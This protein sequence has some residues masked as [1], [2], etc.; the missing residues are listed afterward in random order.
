MS[1]W[2][3]VP[4]FN[5]ELRFDLPYWRMIVEGS[6]F[7]FLFVNDGSTDRTQELIESISL[8]NLR[9]LQLLSNM[10]KAEAIRA[11]C[12]TLINQEGSR[13]DLLGYMDSDRA[14][15]AKEVCGI[16]QET[17]SL[18]YGSFDAIW[19]SRVKLAGRDIQRDQIRH[20]VG[21][22]I[23]TFLG[24]G[25]KNY[26]YDTQCGFKVFRFSSFLQEALDTPFQ[27]RWFIDIE[28]YSRVSASAGSWINVLEI[29]LNSWREVGNSKIRSIAVPSIINEVAVVRSLLKKTQRG[30][31]HGS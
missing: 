20:L 1:N 16:L 5:E 4:V 2:I 6:N 27:T 19:L 29:P 18:L 14:L 12:L 31:F 15:D 25:I 9:H 8:P 7:N 11:G 13:V 30:F 23:A 22:I 17:S 21:R 10:G 3:V 28:L 24:H 26:P